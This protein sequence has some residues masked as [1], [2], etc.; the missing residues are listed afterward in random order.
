MTNGSS[1]KMENHAHAVSLHF[2]IHNF[3]R[4]HGTLTKAAK[5]IHTTPAMAAGLTD[6]VWT[7]GDLLDAALATQPTAPIET[8]PVRRKRFRVIDGGKAD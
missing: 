3:V 6:R 8:A 2:F 1:K 5:G 4:P 7:I